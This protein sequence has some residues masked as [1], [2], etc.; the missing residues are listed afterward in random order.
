MTTDTEKQQPGSP[1]SSYFYCVVKLVY[2]CYVY[3]FTNCIL[4]NINFLSEIFDLFK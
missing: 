3:A 2:S 1:E 4:R